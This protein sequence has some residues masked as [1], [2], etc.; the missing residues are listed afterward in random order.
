MAPFPLRIP[1][2]LTTLPLFSL[3]FLLLLPHSVWQW[4]WAFCAA[5]T[6]L[7]AGAVAGRCTFLSY[8]LYALFYSVWVYPVVAHWQYSPN[9]WLSPF[10]PN[11][12]LGMGTIDFSG[13]GAQR[14]KYAGA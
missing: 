7:M 10:N 3:F 8:V 12:I 2:P 14:R 4:N 11:A 9:G 5:S 1:L 6:T 13:S